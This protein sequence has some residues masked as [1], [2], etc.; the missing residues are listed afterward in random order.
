VTIEERSDDIKQTNL[1]QRK[2]KASQ[3]SKKYGAVDRNPTKRPY[4]YSIIDAN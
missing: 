3:T 4:I 2:P 1:D